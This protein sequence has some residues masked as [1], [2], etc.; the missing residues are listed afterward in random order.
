M[1]REDIPWPKGML[2]IC[3]KCGTY[4]PA[5]ELKNPKDVAEQIRDDFRTRLKKEGLH[6]NLRVLVSGCIDVCEVG[7]QAV[8][9]VPGVEGE[10][11]VLTL[12]PEK[13]RE[14][15]FQKIMKRIQS[16]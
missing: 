5:D 15:L 7:T 9:F 8:A 6:K 4:I 13:D 12:H 3:T 16:K 1:K 11:E 10:V 2:L 14:E